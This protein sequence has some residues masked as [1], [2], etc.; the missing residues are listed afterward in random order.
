MKK[1][2]LKIFILLVTLNVVLLGNSGA[3]VI[4]STVGV[5]TVEVALDSFGSLGII[6][7]V[8]LSSL[9]GAFFLK[10]EFSSL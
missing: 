5:E 2:V 1:I 8:G 10:D 4:G 9:V 3:E 7:M 6:I